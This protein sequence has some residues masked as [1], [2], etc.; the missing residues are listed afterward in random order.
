M[1]IGNHQKPVDAGSKWVGTIAK[2]EVVNDEN[3]KL[4]NLSKL[5]GKRPVVLVFYR[6]VW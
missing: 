3:G 6:G 1:V 2:S 5:F 4:V